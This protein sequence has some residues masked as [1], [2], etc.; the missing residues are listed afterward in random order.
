MS[1]R[2]CIIPIG[3]ETPALLPQYP[4]SPK[5]LSTYLLAL[6]VSDLKSETRHIKSSQVRLETPTYTHLRVISVLPGNTLC[7]GTLL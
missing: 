1:V 7:L 4:K 2:S 5:T 3:C 6:L